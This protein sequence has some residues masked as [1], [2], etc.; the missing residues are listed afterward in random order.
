MSKALSLQLIKGGFSP[1]KD[2]RIKIPEGPGLGIEIDWNI[3][4]R[5]G[6]R[7]YRGTSTTEACHT[8]L[9]RGLKQTMYLKKKKQEQLERTSKA[10]FAIPE[11]PF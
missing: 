5:F 9:D 8:L 1:D 10:Q 3:I 6:K 11:P 4:R 7:I 2:G